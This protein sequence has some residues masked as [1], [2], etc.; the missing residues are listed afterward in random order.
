MLPLKKKVT[1]FQ[2]KA[3]F[4]EDMACRTLMEVLRRIQKGIQVN[5]IVRQLK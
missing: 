1:W 3:A 4:Y 5:A 2:R